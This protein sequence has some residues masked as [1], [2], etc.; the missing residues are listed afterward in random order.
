MGRLISLF[1]LSFITRFFQRIVMFSMVSPGAPWC[2]HVFFEKKTVSPGV[3]WCEM[4]SILSP[5]ARMLASQREQAVGRR[6][7]VR[8]GK[9]ITERKGKTS[10]QTM[11]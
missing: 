5:G 9:H 10:R 6:A 4:F 11:K 3:P 8:R 2:E 1:L 7:E